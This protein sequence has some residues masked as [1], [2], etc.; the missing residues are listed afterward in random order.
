MHTKL[1]ILSL[2]FGVVYALGSALRFLLKQNIDSNQL[3]QA[4]SWRIGLSMLVFFLLL[5]GF[6]LGILEPHSIG[7]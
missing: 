5:L 2:M 3:V 4:L 6:A 7:K 1:L